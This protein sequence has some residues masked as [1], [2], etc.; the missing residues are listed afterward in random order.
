M[1]NLTEQLNRIKNLMLINEQCAGTSPAELEKCEE[2]LEN[3]GYK[4]FNPTET[5]SSCDN[6]ENIKCIKDNF[7]ALSG[8]L[9]VSSAGNTIDDCFVLA[10]STFKTS[11]VPTF[12]FTFYSDNQ[13]ILTFLL[14]DEN[15]NKKLVYRS[16]Y[17]C[18][19]TDIN[20]KGGTSTFKY[21]G[22]FK[23]STTTWDN[24]I[25]QKTSGGAEIDVEINSA[26]SASMK[27]PEGPLRF[28]N[29]LTYYL[30]RRSI[31]SGNA[32]DDGFTKSQIIKIL[33]HTGGGGL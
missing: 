3:N 29:V 20:I 24:G 25:Y 13:V 11:G 5:A 16:T 18:D 9:S 33:T 4:V 17:E 14:N 27:I 32:L 28:G 1:K 22:V 31:I 8:K 19:G 12:Y 2:D 7:S 23:G 10:K 6:N 15:N 26:E 30:N 21:L